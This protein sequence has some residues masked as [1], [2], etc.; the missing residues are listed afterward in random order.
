M[1]PLEAVSEQLNEFSLAGGREARVWRKKM[2]GSE[3]VVGEMSTVNLSLSLTP[4]TA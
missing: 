4:H 1:P 2:R 3:E